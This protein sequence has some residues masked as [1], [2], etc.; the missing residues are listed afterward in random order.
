M[1][2]YE[3]VKDIGD[4]NYSVVRLIRHKETKDLFA[5]KYISRGN[6]VCSYLLLVKY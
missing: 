3:E 6:K 5:V 4:G 1:E 2:K